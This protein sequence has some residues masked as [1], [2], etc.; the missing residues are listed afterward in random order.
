M[1]AFRGLEDADELVRLFAFE[2]RGDGGDG[3]AR[4]IWREVK[5]LL[6]RET[7]HYSNAPGVV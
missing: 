1:G 7:G 5:K 4:L 2:E 6:R 3:E